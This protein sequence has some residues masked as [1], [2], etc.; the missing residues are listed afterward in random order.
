MATLAE[1]LG[2]FDA[3]FSSLKLL[4]VIYVDGPKQKP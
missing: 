3:K 4:K 1:I 2:G